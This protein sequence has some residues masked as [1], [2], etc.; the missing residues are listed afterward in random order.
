MAKKL[1]L[2]NLDACEM[3]KNVLQDN[4]AVLEGV[5][6]EPAKHICL[7]KKY[8]IEANDETENNYADIL[9]HV[10]YTRNA[11]KGAK[12]SEV[13]I[14]LDLRLLSNA[15]DRDWGHRSTI[16]IWDGDYPSTVAVEENTGDV[17]LVFIREE[18]GRKI[19]FIKFGNMTE[20]ELNA[21]KDSYNDREPFSIGIDEDALF[22]L[23]DGTEGYNYLKNNVYIKFNCCNSFKV[24]SALK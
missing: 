11:F 9:L 21:F 23:L 22:E 19:E 24:Y 20:S 16:N 15:G 14:K 13:E 3:L 18:K 7:L 10:E 2:T 17:Y 12:I 6:R 1:P 5:Y 8:S 4:V